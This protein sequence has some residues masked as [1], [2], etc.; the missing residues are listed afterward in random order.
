MGHRCVCTMAIKYIHQWYL[1]YA[2][3]VMD[4][5]SSNSTKIILDIGYNNKE[6]SCDSIHLSNILVHYSFNKMQFSSSS[7]T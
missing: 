4:R 6:D 5:F 2:G 1:S 3:D 7:I